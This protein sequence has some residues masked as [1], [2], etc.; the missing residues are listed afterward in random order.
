[1]DQEIAFYLQ[2]RQHR[3]VW[4]SSTTFPAGGMCICWRRYFASLIF[5]PLKSPFCKKTTRFCDRK[6]VSWLSSSLYSNV[7]PII[8]QCH[9]R[10]LR[11]RQDY[12]WT[13]LNTWSWRHSG[14]VIKYRSTSL[15]SFFWLSFSLSCSLKLIRGSLDQVD[16]K[17]QIT[18]VQPRVLSREQIGQLAGRLSAWVD[19]LNAVEQRIAP[20]VFVSAWRIDLWVDVPC[21]VRLMILE[22]RDRCNRWLVGEV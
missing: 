2:W 14:T 4:S 10:I 15:T 11:R 1:M 21:V 6:S 8:E 18:W 20:E 5:L 22:R 7:M 19:K 16:Q 9:S 13:R 12:R 17:A 3:Q